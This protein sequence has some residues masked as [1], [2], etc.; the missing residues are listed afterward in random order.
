MTQEDLQEAVRRKPFVP[1]RLF[2]STGMT[3]DIRHPDLIV[4]ERRMV[5]I[6]ATSPSEEVEFDRSIRIDLLHVV[7]IED[8][9]P[10]GSS[11]NG[12]V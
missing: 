6:G 12:V 10:L 3:F 4:V 2:V 11:T 9:T 7:A 5:R 8:L 1:I